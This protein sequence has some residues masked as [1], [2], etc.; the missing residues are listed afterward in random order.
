MGAGPK[1]SIL[2][3]G[4]EGPIGGSFFL[5]GMIHGH[6]DVKAPASAGG[7]GLEEQAINMGIAVVVPVTQIIATINAAAAAGGTSYLQRAPH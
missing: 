7:D 4:G 5:L 1:G 2:V 6:Y 3:S